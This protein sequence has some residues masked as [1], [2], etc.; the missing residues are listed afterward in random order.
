MGDVDGT[1][2]ELARRILQAHADLPWDSQPRIVAVPVTGET[3]DPGLCPQLTRSNPVT[4][5][6]GTVC[7]VWRVPARYD[8]PWE[9]LVG[10]ETDGTVDALAVLSEAWVARPQPGT[11]MVVG[12]SHRPDRLEARTVMLMGTDGNVVQTAV[13][14]DDDADS[15][16]LSE[17]EAGYTKG[18]HTPYLRR[19]LNLPQPTPPMTAVEAMQ[20]VNLALAI[21]RAN[22][23]VRR[24]NAG[25]ATQADVFTT[26]L[27]EG[28]TRALDPT[29]TDRTWADLRDL[30]ERSAGADAA[31][32]RWLDD[33]GYGAVFRDNNGTVDD[34]CHELTSTYGP[35]V[36]RSV[37]WALAVE[38][39]TATHND[40]RLIGVEVHGNPDIDID[41]VNDNDYR[42]STLLGA[43]ISA[44]QVHQPWPRDVLPNDEMRRRL[45][46][47]TA[48][49][50]A[51]GRDPH[52]QP[53]QPGDLVAVQHQVFVD[54][55]VPSATF[56]WGRYLEPDTPAADIT[57]ITLRRAATAVE[58]HGEVAELVLTA[59]PYFVD[60]PTAVSVAGAHLPADSFGDRIRMPHKRVFV[61]FDQ[62][63]TLDEHTQVRMD[64]LADFPP[65][66]IIEF[67][68][69][70]YGWAGGWGT[71][72]GDLARYGGGI[73][74]IVYTADDQMRPD[75]RV[76]WVLTTNTD[77]RDNRDGKRMHVL[78]GRISDAV[79]GPAALNLAAYLCWGDLTP[80]DPL[81]L[82]DP[83]DN[84]AWKKF[85]RTSQW[86]KHEPR[87][88]AWGVHVIRHQPRSAG[89]G[90]KGDT[91]R[92]VTGHLRRGHWRRS[93]I[94]IVDEQTG[95]NVGPVTGEDAEYGV[96]YTYREHFIDPVAV[97][98]G[99]SGTRAAVYRLPTAAADVEDAPG[100]DSGD[101]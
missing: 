55:I 6:D 86:R 63:L 70:T 27:H 80:P 81:K 58:Y 52:S 59:V 18:R 10:S 5:D 50:R 25:P 37:R 24:T 88:A 97:A 84:K 14:R 33:D 89:S 46:Q 54:A 64:P 28:L 41:R 79:V 71:A 38:G 11:G 26:A 91:G 40:E 51:V 100:D 39:G 94:A 35:D 13:F 99:P 56:H 19:W 16:D 92:T 60:S 83:N 43:P 101:A 87:G 93:R 3:V 68:A 1:P 61:C 44:A 2:T 78:P 62:D 42:P 30:A 34:V 49:R 73:T 65:E 72:L 77:P 23:H 66:R 82:P 4:L 90:G 17:W 15:V 9:G 31:A 96:T 75:D 21:H 45:E 67:P 22:E 32:A 98:G 20:T 12:V 95:Q 8:K 47:A 76:L 69:H 85:V 7:T 48:I 36:A 53:R 29:E 57:D 74:G